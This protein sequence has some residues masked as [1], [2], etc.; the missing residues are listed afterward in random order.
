VRAAAVRACV[1]LGAGRA[2]SI[3]RTALEDPDE[4]VRAAGL[5]VL[6]E[7]G[8]ADDAPRVREC[9]TDSSPLVRGEAVRALG[10]LGR[11]AD[12]VS[13]GV[14]DASPSVRRAAWLLA[15]K[16]APA[17]RAEV[18]AKAPPEPDSYLRELKAFVLGTN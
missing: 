9:L 13:K 1:S 16:L 10:A 2:C 6:G 15:M 18:F 17:D 8:S 3:G 7:R 5:A 11:T 4:T 12:A 14:T